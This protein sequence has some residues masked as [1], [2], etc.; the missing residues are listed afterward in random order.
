MISE[1]R[2]CNATVRW[3]ITSDLR[4]G[5]A[6]SRSKTIP[7][8]VDAGTGTGRKAFFDF[9]GLILDLSLVPMLLQ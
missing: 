2:H 8:K 4:F 1:T 6:F 7:G 9:F 5:A 3:K